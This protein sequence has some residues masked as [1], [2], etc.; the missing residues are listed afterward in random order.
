MNSFI[1]VWEQVQLSWPDGRLFRGLFGF[2]AAQG[3]VALSRLHEAIEC[4]ELPIGATVD[5]RTNVN[6]ATYAV[7]RGS[8]TH[9]AV[10]AEAVRAAVEAFVRE[11]VT[12]EPVSS[13]A[14]DEEAFLSV[15]PPRAL[16]AKIES[17]F[18]VVVDFKADDGLTSATGGGSQT[19]QLLFEAT[20]KRTGAKVRV[21]H[22]DMLFSKCM[23]FSKRGAIVNA[24]KGRLAHGEGVAAAIAAAA[25]SACDAECRK[26]VRDAGGVLPNGVAVPTSAGPVLNA[27]GT[28]VVVHAVVPKWNNGSAVLLMQQVV[29]AA[30]VEA[31]K[32]GAREVA[33]PLCG[34]GIYGWPTSR[35]AGVVIGELMA[36]AANPD[37]KLT[38]LDLVEFDAPKAAAAADALSNLCCTAYFTTTTAARAAATIISIA[39]GLGI[40]F[41]IA[42]TIFVVGVVSTNA[43]TATPA[44]ALPKHQWYF[45][46]KEHSKRGDG[47]QPYDYDQNQQIVAAWAAFND[48]GPSEVAIVGYTG[49]NKTF[50]PNIPQC[51]IVTEYVIC[52]KPRIEDSRQRNVVSNFER[53]LKREKCTEPPPLFQE[54]VAEAKRVL[55]NSG[56]GDGNSSGNSGNSGGSGGGQF[57]ITH[58]GR[59]G[60]LKSGSGR[61]AAAAAATAARPS[62]AVRGFTQDARA[63]A[64]KL[65]EEV[66]NLK[67]EIEMRIDDAETPPHVLLPDMQKAA[68]AACHGATVTLLPGGQRA[69]V[70]AFGDIAL[71]A[72]YGKCADVH[73]RAREAARAPPVGWV[74]SAQPPA[75]ASFALTS[76]GQG[77]PEW[78]SVASA[79][80]K[81]MP[82]A[83]L[84]RLERVQNQSLW[85]DYAQRRSEVAKKSADGFSA[86]EEWCFHGTR[87]FP[88]ASVCAAGLDFRHGSDGS[89][90]GRALYLAVNAS[91]SDAYSSDAGNGERQFFYVRAALGRPKEMPSNS[92]IR[93][94]PD[95][96]DSVQGTTQGSR[97]HMLYN[98]GLAY[99]EYIVTY[100]RS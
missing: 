72:A 77:S 35:A 2:D 58:D 48:G 82:T 5:V 29:R 92:S 23:L 74:R 62:V 24:A 13:L 87:S 53:Q 98:L 6:T 89:M 75:G 46:C 76:V 63:G 81:T 70:R 96:F 93:A 55:G 41:V 1:V 33:I 83:K 71:D 51:N 50:S 73:A 57:R 12:T 25:G 44:V 32:A 99:P 79:V 100:R 43:T 68:S 47:F 3:A 54:R 20:E 86:N 37:T 34:S 40:S 11:N 80:A 36:Y 31:E 61:A 4:V 28:I 7:V 67:R 65:V 45:Y 10:A 88:V 78:M 38:R 52:F 97:V 17:T 56:G 14:P 30:L 9:V 49:G 26:A 60:S 94:P 15:A 22:G 42:A 91:Y 8:S 90:W 21:L 84:A 66:K 18:S 39:P 95:G 69:V 85:D 59:G 16:A 64:K 19:P 27:R